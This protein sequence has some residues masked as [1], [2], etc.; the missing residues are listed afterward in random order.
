MELTKIAKKLVKRYGLEKYWQKAGVAVF[1]RSV[2]HTYFLVYDSGNRFPIT[3]PL[4]Q[5]YANIALT[6]KGNIMDFTPFVPLKDF[7]GDKNAIYIVYDIA[8]AYKYRDGIQ[9][10]DI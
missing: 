6:Q 8:M 10:Y 4:V 7:N 3:K 5:K 1:Y 2:P 9:P